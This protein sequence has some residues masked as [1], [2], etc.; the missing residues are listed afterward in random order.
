MD[1]R[2]KDI[3]TIG[4]HFFQGRGPISKILSIIGRSRLTHVVISIR[5]STGPMYYNC[6]WGQTSSW[7][8][9]EIGVCPV[10]SIYEELELS[11]PLVDILLPPDEPYDL[12]R[13]VLNYTTNY[14]RH[15]LSCTEAVHRLRT[16]GGK[17]TKGKTAGAL[18]RY[19]RKEV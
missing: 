5:S 19:L 11:L 18:Y 13:V 9:G 16:L 7:F 2:G 8:S 17:R 3:Y 4:Y 10:D 1:K 14:P 12:W 6:T 15:P